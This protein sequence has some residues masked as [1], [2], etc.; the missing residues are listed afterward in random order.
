MHTIG[1]QLHPGE[2]TILE[3]LRLL[4]VL[5]MICFLTLLA[6]DTAVAQTGALGLP[7]S[8]HV[9]GAFQSSTS[10]FRA[11][12]PF[13]VYGEPGLLQTDHRT[14]GGGIIDVGGYVAVWRQLAVGATFTQLGTSDS[15]TMTGSVPH[16]LITN[17][18]RSVGP[19]SLAFK[20][21]EQ[22]THIHIAW[23]FPI[24][25]DERL[26]ITISG[27]P[28]FFSVT[29]GVLGDITVTETGPPFSEVMVNVG[30]REN[31][32]NA[33]GGHVGADVTYMVTSV[34]GLGGFFRFA[35]G[36]VDIPIASDPVPVDVGGVQA[37]G[38]VRVRF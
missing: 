3:T 2:H 20:H 27:G 35:T 36:S 10:E 32:S 14:G 22:T 8:V 1:Q 23:V 38:G 21:R 4:K 37:G 29:R 31:T 30:T 18:P 26:D 15:A 7:V 28:S 34:F 12:L 9:N 24:G 16:P 5:L 13:S 11:K 19:E 6:G 25:S 17:Q 33:W